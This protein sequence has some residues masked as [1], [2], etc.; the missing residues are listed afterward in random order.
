MTNQQ[1]Q[2]FESFVNKSSGLFAVVNGRRS[3]CWIWLGVK[4]GGYGK[5]LSLGGV[6]PIC[7]GNSKW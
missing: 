4:T 5:F 6:A 3:Q 2:K 1:I 7:L